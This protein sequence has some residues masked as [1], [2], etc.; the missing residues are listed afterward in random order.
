MDW[1]ARFVGVAAAVIDDT[2]RILLV[3]HTYGPLNWELPGGAS[4]PG[5]SFEGTALRELLE[6]TG[7]VARISGLTGLYY[8]RE[9]DSH[10]L[11]FRC[12]VEDGATPQPCSGEISDCGFFLVDALPRPISTFTIRRVRD[13]LAGERPR[14]VTEIESLT[15]LE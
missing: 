10:H 14:T 3:R 9:N 7:L 6:E 8:K 13:A 1:P 15:W 12:I 4:E 2:R 11:V 5:E